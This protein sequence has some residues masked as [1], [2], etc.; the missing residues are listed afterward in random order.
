[1]CLFACVSPS[2]QP[3]SLLTTGDIEYWGKIHSLFNVLLSLPF[4]LSLGSSPACTWSYYPLPS[5]GI[6]NEGMVFCFLWSPLRRLDPGCRFLLRGW[7]EGADNELL[8]VP[9]VEGR[10]LGNSVL[11]EAVVFCMITALVAALSGWWEWIE[12]SGCDRI[13][14][15]EVWGV[16]KSQS[17][18]MALVKCL[19]SLPSSQA[20]VRGKDPRSSSVLQ[21]ALQSLDARSY[22]L[23]S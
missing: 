3:P 11:L 22:H 17:V 12:T 19:W 13:H 20:S 5:L 9:G 10:L 4:L 7:W 16:L 2:P 18:Q 8:Y 6:S 21:K 15:G 14:L 23:S 1:M